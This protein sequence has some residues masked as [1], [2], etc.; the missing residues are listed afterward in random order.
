MPSALFKHRGLGLLHTFSVMCACRNNE[1]LVDRRGQPESGSQQL[2]RE[3]KHAQNLL[4]QHCVLQAHCQLERAYI[5]VCRDAQPS[6]HAGIMRG[7]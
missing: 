2:R 4:G 1:E 7:W 3:S 5:H 6:L